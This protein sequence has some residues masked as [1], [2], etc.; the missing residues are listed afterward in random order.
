MR[1]RDNAL[2]ARRRSQIVAAAAGC[3]AAKG[4]HQTSMQEV[5]EAAGMSPGALYRY[6]ASKDAIIEA[7]ANEERAETADLLKHLRAAPNIVDG[8]SSIAAAIVD[9][10]GDPEYGRLTIEIAAEATRNP[11]VAAIFARNEAELQRALIDAL[12]RGQDAGNVDSEL[13]VEAAVALV[14]A[15]LGGIAGRAAFDPDVPPPRL[16][17]ALARLMQR[18]LTP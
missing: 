14:L 6:F 7:M 13:D 3:F 12:R 5:C 4:F 11:K 2:H 8:L 18:L 9:T 1:K 10:L 16:A 17:R 15:L